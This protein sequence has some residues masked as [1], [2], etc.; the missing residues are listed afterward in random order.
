MHAGAPI[1]ALVDLEA[2]EKRASCFPGCGNRIIRT[3]IK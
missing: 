3:V 2:R 1:G